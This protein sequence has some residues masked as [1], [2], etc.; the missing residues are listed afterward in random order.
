MTDNNRRLLGLTGI[1]ITPIGLGVMQFAGG[2]GIMRFMYGGVSVEDMNSII[3]AALDGG[4]N[5]FD[6]AEMY[7]KGQSE[8]GL[9]RGL[10][11]A[12]RSNGDVVIATKWWPLFRTAANIPHTI[13]RRLLF[14]EGFGIDL[15]QIHWSFSFSSIDAEMNAMADLVDQGKIRSVGVSNFSAEQMRQAHAALAKRGLPLASNQVHYSLLAREIEDNGILDAAKELGITIISYS[16]LDSGLLTGK[17]HKDPEILANTPR[18][19]R[20]RLSNR[21]E[22]SRPL[23]STLDSIAQAHDVTIAQVA[24]NWLVNFHGDTVVA[25]PGAS[26]PRHAQESAGAMDFRLSDQ[27]MALID[28]RSKAV[29]MNGA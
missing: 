17:F 12:G 28:E 9:A 19:R 18:G 27:E 15:Y 5:W 26:K 2:S 4:I 8:L 10:E 20:M 29:A 1:E 13:D 7:G 23:I 14:L 25:I 21:I 3:K 11:A 24:L 22:A 16:P 6:T